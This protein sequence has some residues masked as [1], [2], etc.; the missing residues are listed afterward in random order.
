MSHKC[1]Y[2]RNIWQIFNT[3]TN[4]KILKEGIAVVSAFYGG[5][6]VFLSRDVTED[7]GGGIFV[8][9]GIITKY[10]CPNTRHFMISRQ[11]SFM[12]YLMCTLHPKLWDLRLNVVWRFLAHA[13]RHST[14]KQRLSTYSTVQVQVED[15]FIQNVF[16]RLVVCCF[17]FLMNQP[18]HTLIHLL[19]M[20]IC[21]HEIG[22]LSSLLPIIFA[23]QLRLVMCGPGGGRWVGYGAAAQSFDHQ[24]ITKPEKT[25]NCNLYLNHFFFQRTPL[26]TK[27]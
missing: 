11:F 13:F 4:I 5:I 1:V 22:R 14:S 16:L 18:C 2:C 24:P 19:C 8:S 7:E 9:S 10:S 15:L 25:Q 23:P 3:Y 12:I 26:L 20:V 17:F 21:I 6:F 27:Q